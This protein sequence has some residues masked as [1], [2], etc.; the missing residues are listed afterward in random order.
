[1]RQTMRLKSW[2]ARLENASARLVCQMSTL[3]GSAQL[4]PRLLI[5]AKNIHVLKTCSGMKTLVRYYFLWR[6]QVNINIQH[7]ITI[8]LL[9]YYYLD[10]VGTRN[11]VDKSSRQTLNWNSTYSA[12]VKFMPPPLS[13]TAHLAHLVAKWISQFQEEL[14]SPPLPDFLHKIM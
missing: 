14:W 3:H 7:C 13:F 10:T 2:K 11:C 5:K 6:E 1:M 8:R 4:S 9:Y 12:N